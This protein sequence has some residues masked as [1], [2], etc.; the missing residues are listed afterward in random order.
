M[1]ALDTAPRESLIRDGGWQ[2]RLTGSMSAWVTLALLVVVTAMNIALQPTFFS[3]YSLTSNFATFTPLVCAA[4]AQAIV[5]IGGGLDLSIG[6]VAAL[7][8][9]V[10]LTV[11]DGQDSRVALGVAAGVLTGMACGA[12]NGVIVGIVRLQPLIATFATSTVFSG[13]ALVVLPAP[14]GTVPPALTQGFRSMV[15]GVPVPVV[16]V[17]GVL[18]LYLVLSR[19]LLWRH[20]RAVG[21]DREAAFASL[22]PVVRVQV[23][24]FV[25]AGAFAGLAALAI[26]ANSGSG[27][28]F[29][30]AS[31]AL[32]S[33]AAVVLGG[34][35]LSGGRGSG[36]GAVAGALILA[37][38]SNV[39]S[40]FG[41]PTTWRQLV[42]G[43]VIV[44]AIALSVV[45]SRKD[46]R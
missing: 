24:G 34:I 32:D 33:I 22:V 17:I 3:A 14:G 11:M 4:V 5:I 37:I 27:D 42:S 6:S 36:V 7:S 28:P 18:G 26:L 15:A 2:R 16:L 46:S 21:G 9:V 20:V 31:M 40:F 1:S 13:A 8:S 12:V 30:G 39:I 25:V 35:A 23:L 38:T 45:V 10:A 41:V 44:A 29:V 43:V 19:T